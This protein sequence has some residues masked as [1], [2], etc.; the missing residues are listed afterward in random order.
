MAQS[1]RIEIVIQIYIK[2]YRI[3]KCRFE[4]VAQCHKYWDNLFLYYIQH[5]LNLITK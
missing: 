1:Y 3:E 2:K 4:I 5:F